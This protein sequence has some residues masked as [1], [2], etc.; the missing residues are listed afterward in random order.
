MT[1]VLTMPGATSGNTAAA[2]DLAQ[3]EMALRDHIERVAAQRR[4]RNCSPMTSIA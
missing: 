4:A 2:R 1:Y 3:E